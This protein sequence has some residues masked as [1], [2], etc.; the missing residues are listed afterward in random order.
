VADYL[1]QLSYYQLHLLIFIQVYLSRL[2]ATQADT[3]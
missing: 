2:V 1:N 3:S